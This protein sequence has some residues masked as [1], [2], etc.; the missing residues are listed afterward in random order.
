MAAL[1]YCDVPDYHAL[2]LRPSLT[3]GDREI[4][5]REEALFDL[6]LS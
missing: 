5:G 2:L 3:P 1:Q 4:I 6:L